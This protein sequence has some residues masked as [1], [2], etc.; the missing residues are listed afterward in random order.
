MKKVSFSDR[1]GLTNAVLEGYKTMFRRVNAWGF[2]DGKPDITKSEFKVGDIVAISQ[3]YLDIHNEKRLGKFNLSIYEGL[4]EYGLKSK[5]WTNKCLVK[6]DA[7]P[8]RIKITD[9]RLERLQDI[10][11][12]D[13]IK[14]GIIQSG[15]LYFT[16]YNLYNPISNART[17]FEILMKE[18]EEGIWQQNPYVYVYSFE[19]LQ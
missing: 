14:E 12:E 10:S 16:P 15:V 5:G 8:H 4:K 6:P 3:S 17:A 9:V 13:C 11:D 7:M 19:L 18:L 1:L 2:T